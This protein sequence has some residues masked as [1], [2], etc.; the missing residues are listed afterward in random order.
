MQGSS[1]SHDAPFSTKQPAAE[2]AGFV[3]P[4]IT[5][6]FGTTGFYYVVVE[7]DGILFNTVGPYQL[8][9]TE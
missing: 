2:P 3:D 5:W 9:V 8:L 1:S 4:S 7:S 6:T